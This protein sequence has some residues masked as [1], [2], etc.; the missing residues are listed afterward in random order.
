MS[1]VVCPLSLFSFVFKMTLSWIVQEPNRFCHSSTSRDH[2]QGPVQL[3]PDISVMVSGS[4]GGMDV[5][6]CPGFNSSNPEKL[7]D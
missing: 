3:K 2:H 1:C 5:A 6:Y 4:E 7:F